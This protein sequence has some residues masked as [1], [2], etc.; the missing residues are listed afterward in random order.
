MVQ[1][2]NLTAIFISD[3]ITWIESSGLMACFL[4][5]CQ[6]DGISVWSQAAV[7]FVTLCHVSLL[8][9]VSLLMLSSVHDVKMDVLLTQ[10]LSLDWISHTPV[11]LHLSTVH[12]GFY[13]DIISTYTAYRTL[14]YVMTAMHC[15][16]QSNENIIDRM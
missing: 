6:S 12:L 1:K 3:I 14:L 15:I 11:W 16:K 13:K 4:P 5:A 7:L 8:H 2:E 9:R 10:A